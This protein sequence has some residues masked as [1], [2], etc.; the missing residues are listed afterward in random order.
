MNLKT[1]QQA[2]DRRAAR[3]AS[4]AEVNYDAPFR[5]KTETPF[6]EYFRGEMERRKENNTV[7]GGDSGEIQHPSCPVSEE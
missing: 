7:Q 5:F 2:E 3:E 6:L 1:L 4:L